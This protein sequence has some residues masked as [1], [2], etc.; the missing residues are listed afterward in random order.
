MAPHSRA[1]KPRP[2]QPPPPPA[3]LARLD[4]RLSDRLFRAGQGVPRWAYKALEYGGDGVVWLLATATA[5][6]APATPPAARA[7][8][9][10]F[11]LGLL[12]DL[13]LV[14]ALKGAFR[15]SRPVYNKK[16]DFVVVVAVDRYSFPSGHSSRWG[17]AVLAA[18]RA[19]PALAARL[20]ASAACPLLHWLV[21]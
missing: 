21:P 15:R 2:A 1:A 17:E 18:A 7:V 11:L 16:A 6:A 4:A 12:I 9:A 3:P 10:N 5:L 8:W 14:G 20:C 19:I 13:A